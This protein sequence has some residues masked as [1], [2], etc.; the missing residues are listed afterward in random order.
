MKACPSNLTFTA[1]IAAAEKSY[2]HMQVEIEGNKKFHERVLAAHNTVR[3][4]TLRLTCGPPVALPFCLLA[5]ISICY[6]VYLLV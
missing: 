2:L 3:L 6:P 4:H 1:L 5:G